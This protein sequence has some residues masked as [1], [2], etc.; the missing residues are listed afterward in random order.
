MRSGV[1]DLTVADVL[2]GAGVS[3]RTFYDLFDGIDDCLRAALEQALAA[4]RDAVLAAYDPDDPWR[5]RVRAA[6]AALLAFFEDEPLRAHLL[7][8]DSLAA[9]PSVLERRTQVLDRLARELDTARREPA[10]SRAGASGREVPGSALLADGIVGGIASILHERVRA[11]EREL[12]PL[13]GALMAMVVLPYFG[14]AVARREQERPPP[15]RPSRYRTNSVPAVGG[16]GGVR[17]GATVLAGNPLHGLPMRL[18]YRTVCVLRAIADR[19]GASN[20]E[21]GLAADVLDQ[22]QISKLLARLARLGLIRN[23]TADAP[24]RGVANTWRLTDRGADLVRATEA[25][26]EPVAQGG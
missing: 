19:P 1:A 25:N 5:E 24:G 22:G 20:R 16:V 15:P 3:R 12:S 17:A 2:D 26:P 13:Y 11:G 21:I 9:G 10:S 23:D 8:V 6:L 4:A 14:P 7:L 18:T